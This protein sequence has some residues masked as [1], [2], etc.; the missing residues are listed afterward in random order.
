MLDPY[1]FDF[2]LAITLI[3]VKDRVAT[4]VIILPFAFESDMF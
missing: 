3:L 1:A 4:I 2:L